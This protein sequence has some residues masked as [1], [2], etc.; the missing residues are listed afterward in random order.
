MK[1]QKAKASY[2]VLP[3]A[4]AKMFFILYHPPAIQHPPYTFLCN[5]AF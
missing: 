5:L 3:I 2:S 1:L 4:M